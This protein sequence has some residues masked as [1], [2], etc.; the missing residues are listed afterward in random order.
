N[1]LLHGW[2]IADVTYYTTEIPQYALIELVRGLDP[3][4]VHIAGAITY[5]LLVLAAGLLARGRA[6]GRDGLIRFAVAAGIMLAPQFGN[7]THLLLSQ[8][9]HLGTQLPLLLLFLLLDRA[10]RRWYVPVTAA[11]VLTWVIIADQV[12]V[13]DAA[14]PLVL[15]C[16]SRALLAVLR[17]RRSLASQWYE[18]SLVAASVLSY[19]VAELTVRLIGAVGGYQITPVAS[20][21]LAHLHTL[22]RRA[23]V[24][25]E[26]IL[27][28]Y[29]GDWF[30]ISENSPFGPALGGLPLAVGVALAAVHLA[31][32]ALAVW[33]FFRAF[34][35][36]FDPADLIS[37]VLATA[38]AI[39]VTAYTLSIISYG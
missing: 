29:G 32:L 13:L 2:T 30:H 36:F 16:G 38:I 1:L 20:A 37:P 3:E 9:D 39:N 10:P 5:T 25:F 4:V 14:V 21:K 8:P 31:G 17:H 34:R 19:V 26:G 33:G 11:L 6:T 18:L 27:N 7:A 12:A 22:P 35:H 15:V 24:A 28:L 23:V